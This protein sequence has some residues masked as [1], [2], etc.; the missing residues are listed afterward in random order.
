MTRSKSAQLQAM[1]VPMPQAFPLAL[2]WFVYMG[3]LGIFFPYYSLYLR[4]NVGLSGTQLGLVLAIMPLVGIVAQPFWGQVADRTGARSRVLALLALGAAF[5]YLAL[6]AVSGF[7]ALVLATA[8]L[9]TFSTAVL[10]VTISVSLATLR[11]AGPY[12]FG[13]VRVWGTLG[14]LILVIGF[15]WMLHHIQALRGIVPKPGGPSEP[16]L[17]VMFIVTAALVFG[18]AIV[19][20]F[21]PTEGVVALR[22]PRGDWRRLVRNGP[23]IRFL[24]FVFFAYIFLTGPMWIFPIYIRAHGGDMDA[25]RRMW[26]L[27]L[28]VEIP[29]VA[30]SGA[31]LKR[32]GARGLLGLGVFAGG[33]RWTVSG[34][35]D[36][37]YVIYAVQMLHGV[38]V[39]GLLLG[40]PLYLDA[41]VP[42][43][44]RS[45]GQALLSMVG[46]G[47]AGIISNT[48]SGWLLEHVG[49]NA[50]YVVGGVG[51]LALGCLAHKIL[52]HVDVAK[53]SPDHPNLMSEE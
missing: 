30:Y 12:A 26:I 34:L 10:P 40:G 23:V 7:T 35:S 51:A 8:A 17:E 44:L 1:I 49:P 22:A 2:F 38:M 47:V 9:A 33:L 53:S 46:I 3:A 5:G 18:A 37:L 24:I 11:D 45:T 27:M 16:G 28:I 21:F 39:A 41:V 20:L 19:S 4:E 13:R 15:P 42:E 14:F 29:L 31:G 6:A 36:D 32:L 52:P 43:R 48:A 25:I 50:P